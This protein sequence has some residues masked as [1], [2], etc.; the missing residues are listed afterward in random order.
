MRGIYHV[1][2]AFCNYSF[3]IHIPFHNSYTGEGI[4]YNL[5]NSSIS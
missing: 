1:G 4:G 2:M 5:A 3:H